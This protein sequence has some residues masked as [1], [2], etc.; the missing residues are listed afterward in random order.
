[1]PARIRNQRLNMSVDLEKLAQITPP[2]ILLLSALG[3]GSVFAGMRYLTDLSNKVAPQ[4]PQSNK[5]KLQLQNPM[6][7]SHSGAASVEPMM[8]QST[9]G[10]S[11][12]AADL[13][14]PWFLRS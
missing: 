11:K 4:K 10:I 2:E 1:M 13:W 9:P 14:V 5:I 12:A 7:E 6:A 8:G 3:G